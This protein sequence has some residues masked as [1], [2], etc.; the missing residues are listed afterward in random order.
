MIAMARETKTRASRK[1]LAAREAAESASKTTVESKASS[2][3]DAYIESLAIENAASEHTLRNYRTDLEA[4]L[5][6]CARREVDPFTATHKQLRAFLGELDA[7]RYSRATI[8]RRLSSLRGFYRWMNLVG[9]M[10]ADPAEA[11]SGPKQGHHLPH[12]LKKAEMERLLNTPDQQ[13]GSAPMS[14][15]ALRDRAMLEFLYASGARISEAAALCVGDIDF[16]SKLVKLFGK[17]RKERIVPLHDLCLDA[18]REYLDIG[19]QALLEGKPATDRFFISNRGNPMSA[20][21]LRKRYKTAIR[22]AGLDASLSPHDMRH[23]FATDLLE[24]DAD[25]RSVQE[26][27]GHASLSTTQVYTHL[28]PAHLKQAHTQAHPRA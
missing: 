6:W 10:D 24:G 2:L 9:A 21:A 14:P 26:M 8:N 13:A 23:T 15:E 4:F 20:D 22:Q 5:R 18:M 25:L 11:L 28:S 12:V 16:Q 7:A 17:G 27:L 1:R 3:L 19:R